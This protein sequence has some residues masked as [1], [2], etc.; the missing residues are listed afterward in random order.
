MVADVNA[1]V[2]SYTC[3][4]LQKSDKL[5]YLPDCSCKLLVLGDNRL[6]L[7]VVVWSILLVVLALAEEPA[8]E[9]DSCSICLKH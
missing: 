7:Y 2:M 4:N 3:G 8:D 1:Y 5:M 9:L 6:G